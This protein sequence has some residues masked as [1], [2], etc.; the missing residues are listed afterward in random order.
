MKSTTK[1]S[2]ENGF[3]PK[4]EFLISF[5]GI[6]GLIVLHNCNQ[7]PDLTN[8][9]EPFGVLS[10]NNVSFLFWKGSLK[11]KNSLNF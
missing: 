6:C 2:S 8:K 4:N 5:I 10:I 3:S 11:I 7:N 9:K 1:L